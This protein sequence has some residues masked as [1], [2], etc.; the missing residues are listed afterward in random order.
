LTRT[1]TLKTSHR[2]T[3]LT[4]LLPSRLCSKTF[5]S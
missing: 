3:S 5:K 1:G 2:Q 4:C